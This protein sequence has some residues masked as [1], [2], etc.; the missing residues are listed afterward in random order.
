MALLS[1]KGQ[2]KIHFQKHEDKCAPPTRAMAMYASVNAC[3]IDSS[4]MC[5]TGQLGMM[6]M[7][8]RDSSRCLETTA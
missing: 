7:I 8:C 1:S 4:F 2:R 5:L 3:V 6:V